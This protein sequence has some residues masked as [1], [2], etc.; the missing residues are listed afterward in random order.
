VFCIYEES[1]QHRP[2]N[3]DGLRYNKF[4]LAYRIIVEMIFIGRETALLS[5]T[6][7]SD[8]TSSPCIVCHK[9]VQLKC[10][11]D[12]DSG[13]VWFD[14]KEDLDGWPRVL[15]LLSEASTD[16]EVPIVRTDPFDFRIVCSA[17]C[18]RVLVRRR[19]GLFARIIASVR[20]IIG[21]EE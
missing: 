9:E 17:R 19:R 7:E 16:P 10:V 8:I 1:L 20:R 18:D 14:P 5:M 21:W 2:V 3:S 15:I 4:S 6:D 11:Y 13:K 12:I